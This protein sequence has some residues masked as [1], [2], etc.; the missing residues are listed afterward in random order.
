[1]ANSFNLDLTEEELTKKRTPPELYNW[2]KQKN[3]EIYYSS[4]DGK[5]AL[6][7]HEGLAKQFMEELLPLRLCG[8]RE[9]GDTDK[10]FLQ[11]VKG[12][13]SYDAVVTD[14][15]TKPQLLS[16]L[17]ITQSHEG[18]E[19]YLRDVVFNNE[20]L[21]FPLGKVKKIGTK[22]TGI[23]VSVECE[24]VDV[25]KAALNDLE[26]I[27]KAA[28]KKV[29]KPYPPNTSLIIYFDDRL[30]FPRIIDDA[31][32]DDFVKKHILILDLKFTSL[33]LV[34]LYHVFRKFNL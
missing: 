15:R 2:W 26:K 16:Y 13:Q 21:V 14:Q 32:L 27:L 24:A 18:E 9:Y 8:V 4:D 29:G 17:E 25:E 23:Q 19:Q 22:R 10:V 28:K 3:D 5:K 34:G 7:L 33:Y 20:G 11:W 30:H 1:M 31:H 6:R 12:N